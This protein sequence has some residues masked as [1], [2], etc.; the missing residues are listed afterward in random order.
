MFLAVGAE[1]PYT[2]VYDFASQEYYILASNLLKKYYKNAEDYLI[3]RTF[4]GKDLQGLHYEP[5]FDYITKSFSTQPVIAGL[6]RNLDPESSS[7]GQR[8]GS[9]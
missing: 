9:G 7:G 1:I 2:M 6:T 4:K 8:E 3:I 5:L